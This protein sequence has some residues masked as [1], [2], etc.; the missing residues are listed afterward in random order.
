MV[1]CTRLDRVNPLYITIWISQAQDLYTIDSC[2]HYTNC[3]GTVGLTHCIAVMLGL[4]TKNCGLG[5]GL[6]G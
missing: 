3:I 1:N 4:E 6:V 5:F 2:V